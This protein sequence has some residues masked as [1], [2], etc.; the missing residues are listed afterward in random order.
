[1]LIKQIN[2]GGG[3]MPGFGIFAIKRQRATGSKGKTTIINPNPLLFDKP[4]WQD[5]IT[6]L[7]FGNIFECSAN[8]KESPYEADAEKRAHFFAHTQLGQFLACFS[9][10]SIIASNAYSVPTFQRQ[11]YRAFTLCLFTICYDI[12]KTIQVNSGKTYFKEQ[13]QFGYFECRDIFDTVGELFNQLEKFR[14]EL[15]IKKLTIKGTSKHPSQ[16]LRFIAIKIQRIL[17]HHVEA[18]KYHSISTTS[19]VWN[20]KTQQHL[21]QAFL[22]FFN[23]ALWKNPTYF[24]EANPTVWH[25]PALPI[26]QY[27][28]ECEQHALSTLG[29]IYRGSKVRNDYVSLRDAAVQMQRLFRANHHSP[30]PAD[31]VRKTPVSKR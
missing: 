30:Q 12:L 19:V 29:A 15:Q 8:L 3:N 27:E 22:D 28:Q 23:T 13:D 9:A 1:M 4:F 5:R 20:S 11:E 18:L 7:N 16:S 14:K 2:T 31:H 6:P 21:L 10:L 26:N 17:L 25:S 24:S